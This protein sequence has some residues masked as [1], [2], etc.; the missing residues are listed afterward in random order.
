M[1]DLF[2]RTCM[3]KF[4]FDTGTS[5][6]LFGMLVGVL[7]RLYLSNA[8]YFPTVLTMLSLLALLVFEFV[9]AQSHKRPS[10]E[11]I[12]I[13]PAEIITA[14]IYQFSARSASRHEIAA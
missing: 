6:C 5:S 4:G 3:M 1:I 10:P 14:K 2:Y 9:H 13:K 8:I 12:E 11:T 7:E